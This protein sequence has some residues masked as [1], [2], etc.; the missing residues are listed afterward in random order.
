MISFADLLTKVSHYLD[1]PA[2]Q[3]VVGYSGGV[4]SHLLLATIAQLSGQFTQHDYLAVHVNHGLSDNA[5]NWQDGCQNVCSDLGMPF[6]AIRVQV[7]NANKNGLEAA[8]REARYR[9]L[10]SVAEHNGL[11][12]LG[13]HLD[14]QLETVLLQLKRG[15]G[16]KGLSAMPEQTTNQVGVCVVR[17][18]LSVT[19]QQIEQLAR[20]K[21]L[22]WVDDESNQ[23]LRFDRNFLRHQI[24]PVLTKR[25]PQ[26]AASVHRSAQLCAQQQALLDEV[27][28]GYLAPLRTQQD[29]LDITQ[30]LAFSEHWQQQIVRLWLETREIPMP[31]Q[32]VIKQ[33]P[34]LLLAKDDAEPCIEFAGFQLR[35]FQQQLYCIDCMAEIT[36]GT[37]IE[38]HENSIHLPHFGSHLVF[39]F[40]K[41]GNIKPSIY[42]QAVPFSHKFKPRGELHSKPLK[43]WFKIWQIPPWERQQSVILFWDAQ[44]I[45]VCCQGQLI[46]SVDA[47]ETMRQ[48]IS[49][50]PDPPAL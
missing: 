16:P 26:I 46:F 35:R 40:S 18:F 45:A 15:A 13:Q 22:S 36:T 37:R 19:R 27:T 29:T 50:H 7:K 9:A 34:T 20:Q 38:L 30:L 6:K 8:A 5:Q 44:A 48:I 3:V 21:G 41:Y 24:L 14:D 39:D 2:C 12:L 17:P 10:Y 25:W 33:L 11:L 1:R 43:Q 28:A 47:D 32:A 4:D 31:S 42:L 23:D 49:W